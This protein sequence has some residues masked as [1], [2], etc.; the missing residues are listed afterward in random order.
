MASENQYLPAIIECKGGLDFTDPKLSA[1]VGSLSECLNFEV[2]DRLGYSRI[3]GYEK[4]DQGDYNS[5]SIYTNTV[6]LDISDGSA[7]FLDGEAFLNNDPDY[8]NED[9]IFGYFLGTNIVNGNVVWQVVVTNYEA[10]YALVPGVSEILG[11][12]SMST[13]TFENAQKL[14]IGAAANI[15]TNHL[16]NLF[17]ADNITRKAPGTPSN[18]T[19]ANGITTGLQW[20]KTNLYSITDMLAFDFTQTGAGVEVFAGDILTGVAGGP[21]QETLV[22]DIR[23]S[24]GSWAAGT[25]AGQILLHNIFGNANGAQTVVRAGV[26]TA[27]ITI[28]GVS[29]VAPWGA[30]M[31][32]TYPLQG[33]W[34]L[35]P[36]GYEFAFSGGTSAGP[37]PV[38]NRGKGNATVVP[39]T[40]ISVPGTVTQG[41]SP[42][43]T[44]QGGASSLLDGIATREINPTAG[45][46]VQA[47][48]TARFP[49][50]IVQAIN[51]SA[52]QNIPADSEITGFSVRINAAAPTASLVKNPYFLIKPI[53]GVELGNAK[54]TPVVRT[55]TPPINGN[56]V[57]A[58]D[59]ILGGPD[60][61]W[62]I[63]DLRSVMNAGFGFNIAPRAL[64]SDGLTVNWQINYVE[65]TVYYSGSVDTFYFWNGTDDVQAPIT[66]YYVDD[67][68]WATNDAHGYMQVASITPVSPSTRTYIEAGDEIRTSPGGSGS[69]IATVE[70]S[71]I[72]AY[73]PSLAQLQENNS[74]YQMMVANYYGNAEWESIYGVSG[75]GQ[76]FVYDGFYFR[77]IYTGLSPTLDKPRHL[78]YH[79]G[80][81][82]LGYNAG[83]VTL[84]VPGEPENYDGTLGATS[85]DMGDP[86]TGLLRMNGTSLGVFC[87]GS[88]HTLIGTSIDNY[89]YTTLSAAEG[90]IEYTVLDMGKPV[91]C[92]NKGIS[93]FS[94]TEA[95][96]NFLGTRLS[97]SITPWL[98]PRLQGVSSPI[99][100]GVTFLQKGTT[101]LLMGSNGVLFATVCRSKNQYRLYFADAT[102]LTM[103]LQ[104]PE[105]EPSFTQQVMDK[106]TTPA[107]IANAVK[108]TKFIPLAFSSCIDEN[109]RERIHM[110]HYDPTR[111]SDAGEDIHYVYEMEQSWSFEGLPIT[112]MFRLNENFFGNPFDVDTL[113]KIAPHGLSLGYAPLEVAVGVDYREPPET[114]RASMNVSLPRTT[115]ARLYQDQKAVMNITQS[116]ARG[117]SFNLK[118]FYPLTGNGIVCPPF[119]VQMLLL[120]YKE[121]KGDV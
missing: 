47:A 19:L 51:F 87:R 102:C 18:S 100:D 1:N 116:S 65:L 56:F 37:P 111:D 9:K 91:Y 7:P 78:A 82:A 95:Y 107:L 105:M 120:Q 12:N 24:S 54:S 88:I 115:D 104:G 94:Q 64:G 90:A 36:M 74:R 62:G 113:S 2:S 41:G 16:N 49:A 103:T 25:A 50:T 11:D 71:A 60:D 117:R 69:L 42:A 110:S 93:F 77:R 57:A 63:S 66:N 3:M 13:G 80:T 48:S 81:L 84:S 10:F 30:G 70:S 121:G 89:S 99:P 73:L 21:P 35:V 109:G 55:T 22:A 68:A 106:W 20:Y 83:N 45:E 38:F 32:K 39:V 23:I 5:S 15:Q 44:L 14:A 52:A 6:M 97:A 86:V 27:S 34:E 85:I 61:S 33:G 31:Y 92:S 112:Y 98:L 43:W 53:N 17:Y 101:N 108:Y 8:T 118:F 119:S 4:F 46:Y 76:A 79:Q 29:D 96:G 28:T 40:A 72:Y 67:G 26:A 75:A 114:D 58:D 59:Y